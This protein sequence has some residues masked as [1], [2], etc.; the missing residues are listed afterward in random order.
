MPGGSRCIADVRVHAGG[1]ELAGRDA[2]GADLALGGAGIVLESMQRER[3][4]RTDEQCG[5]EQAWQ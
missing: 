4:L 2:G 5:K 3:A 1:G